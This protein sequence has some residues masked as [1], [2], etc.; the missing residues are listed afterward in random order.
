[1]IFLSVVVPFHTDGSEAEPPVLE[2]LRRQTA[3]DDVE[4]I[5]VANPVP[6][7]RRDDGVRW[8]QS[9]P[10]GVGRARNAGLEIARG[11]WIYFVD[12]DCELPDAGHLARVIDIARSA[13]P[14]SFFG[15]GYHFHDS[16]ATPASVAYHQVQERWLRSG[17]SVEHGW[18]HF[19]GGNLAVPR[20]AFREHRFD[21]EIAFGGSETELVN[22]LL[23]YGY[24][25]VLRTEISVLHRHSLTPIELV[26]KAFRQ[27]Y[28]QERLSREK[29]EI[30]TRNISLWRGIKDPSAERFAGIYA[31]AFRAGS[32]CFKAGRKVP[33]T[34]ALRWWLLRDGLSLRLEFLRSRR[35][36]L[37]RMQSWLHARGPIKN[38]HG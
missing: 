26:G 23:L 6:S 10:A 9:A 34:M 33:G 32:E 18:A 38:R 36:R 5:V 11:A 35:A 20:A 30:V 7:K 8:T 37:D 3:I 1:M 29:L 4:F 31:R 25:G 15:G 2:S 28:T 24:Q 16:A 12:A 17:E 13:S 22:R 21:E 27:G 19:L 14:A